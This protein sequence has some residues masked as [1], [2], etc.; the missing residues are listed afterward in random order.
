MRRTLYLLLFPLALAGCTE[1]PAK[2]IAAAESAIAAA[3][4]AGAET[5]AADRLTAAKKALSDARQRVTER[6][7]R[8]ALS[9]ANEAGEK[10]RAA[11]R[12]AES[13]KQLTRAAAELARD[14]A[15]IALDEV[16]PLR[17]DAL[18]AR[19]PA[20]AFAA[21]EPDVTEVET[22]IARVAEA[23]TS[24]DLSAAQAAGQ[25]ARAKAQVLPERFRQARTE[26][27]A[28]HPRHGRARPA[29]RH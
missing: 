7:F 3:E 26:W 23:L 12:S 21:L 22:L 10:A 2:E 24:G 14:E 28:A 17:Q 5:Y 18:K 19:I 11:I 29:K 20:E 8:A 6:D 25:S 27:E 15:R 1:P 9:S 13:S 4:N 16:P